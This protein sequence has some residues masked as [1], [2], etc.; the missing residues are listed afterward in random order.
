VISRC[1]RKLRVYRFDLRREII[2][3]AA[4]GETGYAIAKRFR[5][6]GILPPNIC[7]RT[8]GMSDG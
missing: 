1:L 4:T 6:I 8:K 2:R 5:S 7:S 3:R